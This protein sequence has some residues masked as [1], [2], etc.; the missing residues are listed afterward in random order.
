MYIVCNSMDNSIIA[1]NAKSYIYNIIN[2]KSMNIILN[3][4]CACGVTLIKINIIISINDMCINNK[5]LNC[6]NI[7]LY[8][9]YHATT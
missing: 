9:G 3:S 5:P 6:P 4:A 8:N 7:T 2:S 1:N